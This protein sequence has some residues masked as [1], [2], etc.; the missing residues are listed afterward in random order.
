MIL[1]RFTS[2]ITTQ[3][4]DFP[5]S[6]IPVSTT[7]PKVHLYHS[8]EPWNSG[9]VNQWIDD[10]S[11]LYTHPYNKGIQYLKMEKMC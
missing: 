9:S 4:H 1:K 2:T 6:C 11:Q 5:I 10:T 8:F 7:I 3:L